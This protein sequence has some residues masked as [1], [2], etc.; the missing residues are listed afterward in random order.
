MF[1]LFRDA[2]DQVGEVGPY[3]RQVCAAAKP[4]VSVGPHQEVGWSTVVHAEAAQRSAGVVVQRAVTDIAGEVMHCDQSC[5][6]V[7][8]PGG[9]GRWPECRRSTQQQ[10][11]PRRSERP[12]Q[13]H[14]PTVLRDWRIG[15]P[16][17]GSWSVPWR[18]RTF[19]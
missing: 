2:D 15:K 7:G 4:D 18:V 5:V 19:H 11:E 9:R 3:A 17:A 13:R 1:R 12:L 6:A 16:V 14:S 8:E 10:V